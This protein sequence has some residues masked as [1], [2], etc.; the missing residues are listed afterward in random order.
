MLVDQKNAQNFLL[1]FVLFCM[2]ADLVEE[3][4]DFKLDRVSRRGSFTSQVT[5]SIGK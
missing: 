3:V 4:G 5:G 2:T 1:M